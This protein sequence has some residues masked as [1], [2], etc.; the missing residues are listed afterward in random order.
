MCKTTLLHNSFQRREQE[1]LEKF[2]NHSTSEKETQETLQDGETTAL[3]ASSSPTVTTTSTK[4]TEYLSMLPLVHPQ[5]DKIN[6]PDTSQGSLQPDESFVRGTTTPTS[7]TTHMSWTLLV[8]VL[9]VTL[10]S[11]FQFGYATGVMNN[12][13]AFI[14]EYFHTHNRE[15]TLLEWSTV[16]SAYGVGGLLGSV[17]GPKIIGRYTGRRGTLLINNIFLFLSSYLITIAPYWWY[18]VGG[19]ICIGIVAGVATA[20]VPTYLAEISPV[21]V[22]GGIATMHQ[23]AIT[24]GILISQCLSTPSLHLLGSQQLWQWLF[25]VPAV[26]GAIQLLVLPWL[27]ESPSYLY[28]QGDVAGARRAIAKFQSSTVVDEYMGYIESE[29]KTAAVVT[30]AATTTA[31]PSTTTTT[32]WKE[33]TSKDN[34]KESSSSMTVAQLFHDRTLR[35]QL[36]VGVVV[37]LMM[38][39]S[40]IDAVF[41]KFV[42]CVCLILHT[43]CDDTFFQT[44]SVAP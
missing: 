20:V 32:T 43:D 7:T 30:A 34:V 35:K 29:T 16:V 22:R 26:C 37:Q 39:F 13:R 14:M 31:E 38:Q 1:K 44:R 2:S 41:C 25:V 40:G 23:L 8:T 15:Y 9:V 28:L 33:E 4:P 11:S 42:F 21:A 3:L 17:V 36:V 12:S 18:Q 19:R 24:V 10:G 5:T 27:P 6:T